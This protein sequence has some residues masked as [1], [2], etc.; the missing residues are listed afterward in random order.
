MCQNEHELKKVKNAVYSRENTNLCNYNEH[1]PL[2]SRTQNNKKFNK[3]PIFL[4]SF[5]LFLILF[6]I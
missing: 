6:P 3:L 1:N 4:I 2:E 5:A